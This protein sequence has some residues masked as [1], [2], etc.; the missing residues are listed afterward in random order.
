MAMKRRAAFIDKDGTLLDNVPYNVDPAFVSYTPN[1][2]EGLRLLR[3]SGYDLVLI[4]NQSGIARG[5]FDEP[6]LRLLI[7]SVREDLACCGVEFLDAYY[8]PHH[9]AGVV[10]AYACDCLC[11]KPKP[12]LI[13]RAAADH[14]IDLAGSYVIGDILDDIEAG[15]RA[16][17]RTV[18]I[19][20]GSETEWRLGPAREPDF[21]AYDLL[22]AA[23][24]I[25]RSSPQLS[26][27]PSHRGA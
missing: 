10:A 7:D 21:V 22:E 24:I 18:L 15:N 5:Y 27:G 16:G 23:S 17:C 20:C 14:D 2:V 11:R 25:L 1:A 12:G 6:S 8:C 19:E 26:G 3:D 4:S 9:P 13:S